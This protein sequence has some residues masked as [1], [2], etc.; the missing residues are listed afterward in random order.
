[1]SSPEEIAMRELADAHR[2]EI[3]PNYAP[4]PVKPRR[5]PE[6]AAVGYV[7]KSILIDVDGSEYAV[8][9]VSV[10]VTISGPVT[11]DPITVAVEAGRP[12][13]RVDTTEHDDCPGDITLTPYLRTGDDRTPLGDLI[14]CPECQPP[15]RG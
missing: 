8:G 2:D 4:R 9:L 1:M 12:D 11:T 15:Q 10:P 5:F 7:D 6:P 3:D 14:C 13:I